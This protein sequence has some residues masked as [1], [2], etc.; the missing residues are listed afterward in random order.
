VSKQEETVCCNKEGRI[1]EGKVMSFSEKKLMKWKE[2]KNVIYL[3]STTHEMKVV[4][5]R[6]F[7]PKHHQEQ[8]LAPD[9][10]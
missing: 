10:D 5:T 3:T 1:K 9:I 8:K 6:V 2:E 4:S 7:R